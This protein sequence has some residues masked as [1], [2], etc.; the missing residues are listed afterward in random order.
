MAHAVIW[1]NMIYSIA[2]CDYCPNVSKPLKYNKT[3][4][5]FAKR[6]LNVIFII[7]FTERCISCF[8]NT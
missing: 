7:I 5:Q 1:I 8:V 3:C 2:S 6:L 4:P